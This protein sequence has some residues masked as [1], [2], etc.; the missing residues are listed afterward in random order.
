ML[1]HHKPVPNPILGDSALIVEG[2]SGWTVNWGIIYS[3]I[4]SP[5][6]PPH[7][8]THTLH[9]LTRDRKRRISLR[10]HLCGMLKNL[11]KLKTKCM[12]LTTPKE[13]APCSSVCIFKDSCRENF[14]SKCS[15]CATIISGLLALQLTGL[16]AWG[17]NLQ[18]N[19]SSCLLLHWAI[20]ESPL[21]SVGGKSFL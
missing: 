14:L 20:W 4:I 3:H 8:H 12:L 5:R 15:W 13:R 10:I 9:I 18:N 1:I 11:R 21:E 7:T 17:D 16:A 6:P 2:H 19:W